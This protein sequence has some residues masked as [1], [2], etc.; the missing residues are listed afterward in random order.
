MTS[1]DDHFAP[2][3]PIGWPAFAFLALPNRE[4]Y[5]FIKT[6]LYPPVGYP[7]GKRLGTKPE[8]PEG[9]NQPLNK[10]FGTIFGGGEGKLGAR[11]LEAAQSHGVPLG[12]GGKPSARSPEATHSTWCKTRPWKLMGDGVAAGTRGVPWGIPP[13]NIPRV[14]RAVSPGVSPV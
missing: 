12:G 6:N 8:Y 14:S 1:H 5:V 7:E 4:I 10:R 2:R 13:G 3:L 11:P 9:K